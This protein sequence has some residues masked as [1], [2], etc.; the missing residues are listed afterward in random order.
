MLSA[1]HFHG[2]IPTLDANDIHIFRFL[3]ISGLGCVKLAV[4]SSAFLITAWTCIGVVFYWGKIELSD[5]EGAVK[6]ESGI[7]I[8]CARLY[9]IY[10]V[11]VVKKKNSR[12][13]LIQS[14]SFVPR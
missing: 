13:V 10:G 12:V 3:G 1:D 5:L 2:C 9:G 14:D 8:F 7:E 11:E 6:S 4:E